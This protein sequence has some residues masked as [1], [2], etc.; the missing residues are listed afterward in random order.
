MLSP[1]NSARAKLPV[2]SSSEPLRAY[3]CTCTKES[4]SKSG[5]QRGKKKKAPACGQRA[6]PA[7]ESDFFVL[8]GD[9]FASFCDGSVPPRFKRIPS[10][11]RQDKRREISLAERK[12]Q[13]E[14]EFKNI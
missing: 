7:N 10:P 3:F 9:E 13:R 12:Q 14:E 8:H 4:G 5:A 1:F 6:A 11:P 2:V